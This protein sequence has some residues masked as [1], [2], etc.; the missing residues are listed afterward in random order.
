MGVIHPMFKV[1]A[2]LANAV[3]DN[4]NSRSLVK[5]AAEE[6]GRAAGRFM[7]FTGDGRKWINYSWK[8]EAN[9]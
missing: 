9:T 7:A 2:I 4:S 5:E 1:E 6:Y 8:V 3:W